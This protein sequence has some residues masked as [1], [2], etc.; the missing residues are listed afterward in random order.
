MTPGMVSAHQ[1][2]ATLPVIIFPESRRA[3]LMGYAAAGGKL[4]RLDEHLIFKV[5]EQC[6]ESKI[7]NFYTI[8]V[9]AGHGNPKSE[10]VT[11][12]AIPGVVY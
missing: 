10:P 3:V 4:S 2:Q 6:S 9:L 12:L 7:K 11:A 1:S 8:A 5:L